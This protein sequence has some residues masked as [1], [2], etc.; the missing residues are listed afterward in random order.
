MDAT[1]CPVETDGA[2]ATKTAGEVDDIASADGSLLVVPVG[3]LEQHGRHLPTATDSLLVE[4]MAALATDRADVPAVYTPPVW[5]GVSPHHASVGGTVSVAVETLLGT[6][7][8][9]ADSGIDDG[10]DAVLLL[11]GHGGNISPV[12]AATTEIGRRH[13]GV[14]VVGCTYFQLAASFIDDLR[15]SA[16]GGMMH[17]GEFE[18]ALMLHLYPDLVGD[19]RAA[20][21]MD[22]DY[23]RA[24]ADMFDLGPVGA[25]R[26][27]EEYSDSGAIGD[28]DVATAEQGAAILDLLGDELEALLAA[29]HDQA[30]R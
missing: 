30:S 3:S 21:M 17:G 28:P 29:V 9:V 15:E 10:F 4:S 5:T 6:L 19:D 11:N 18:T 23:E 12:G 26:P 2:W 7:G 20:A 14:E 25:Y 8:E 16:T 13:P 27:F 24:T 1:G 22:P